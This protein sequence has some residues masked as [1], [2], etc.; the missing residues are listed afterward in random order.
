[1]IVVLRASGNT[2]GWVFL[3]IGLL[4]SLGQAGDSLFFLARD[5][6]GNMTVAKIATIATGWMWFPTLGMLC[7][8]PLLL[9]PTGRLHS[10]RWRPVAW[11][12]GAALLT[13]ALMLAVITITQ[14]DLTIADPNADI[15]APPV[16]GAVF[17]GAAGLL[18]LCAILSVASLFPRWRAADGT[19]RQQLKWFGLGG[20]VLLAGVVAGFFDGPVAAA[21]SEVSTLAPLVAATVAITRYR[22]YDIDRLLSRTVSYVVLTAVLVGLYLSVITLLTAMTSTVTGQS[23]LAVAAA[24][25]LAAGAFQPLRRRIQGA[26][27]RRF[28]RAR[29][30]AVRTADAYRAR[31]RDE[32]DLASIG[33]DLV[34]TVRATV[35][36]SLVAVWLLPAEGEAR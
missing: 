4:F 21:A 24:T 17:A 9:F 25:L 10:R 6:F 35:A 15:D 8:F 26:V 36:P 3:T 31:L 16:L 28:N 29:Y 2:L 12:A 33:D 18:V 20:I 14:L 27:D 7:T 19:A 11:A 1:V 5:R 23:P 34:S 32:L 30:D 13:G 22:L